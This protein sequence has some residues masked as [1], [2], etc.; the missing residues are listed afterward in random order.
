MPSSQVRR[1]FWER[2]VRNQQESGLSGRAWCEANGVALA[3]FYLWRKKLSAAAPAGGASGR[4]SSDV[5]WLSVE[6]AH[7]VGASASAPSGVTLRIGSVCVEIATGFDT[8]AL[9]DVLTV[10]ESRC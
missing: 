4:R 7:A 6:P 5:Q 1:E 3:S 10:L 8:R 9:S 2:V